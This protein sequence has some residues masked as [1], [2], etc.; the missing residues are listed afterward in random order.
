ML[1]KYVRGIIVNKLLVK[2]DEDPD[3]YKQM[4]ATKEVKLNIV[5]SL[6]LFAVA[7]T[8]EFPLIQDF[9]IIEEYA[10]LIF[11]YIIPEDLDTRDLDTFMEIIT[12]Y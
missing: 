9:T 10:L 8:K 3:E 2:S 7:L 6:Y 1:A 4:L 12:I 11:T 5:N